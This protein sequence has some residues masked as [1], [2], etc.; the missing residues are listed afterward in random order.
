VV[1]IYKIIHILDK[2]YKVVQM[3]L[4]QQYYD[5]LKGGRSGAVMAGRMGSGA[6][7]NIESRSEQNLANAL[8]SQAGQLSLSKLCC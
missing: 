6:Q 2:H 7:Q 4:T 8:T 5:A 1:N 3:L